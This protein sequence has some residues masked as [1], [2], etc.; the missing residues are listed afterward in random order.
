MP[1]KNDT[2]EKKMT[3]LDKLKQLSHRGS[4][5]I[6]HEEQVGKKRKEIGTVLKRSG[7]SP[8]CICFFLRS[9]RFLQVA[10]CGKESCNLIYRFH[11]D[12]SILFPSSSSACEANY[13]LKSILFK[14]LIAHSHRLSICFLSQNVLILLLVNIW[15]HSFAVV[16]LVFDVLLNRGLKYT[17]CVLLKSKSFAHV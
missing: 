6:A 15:W 13:S 12:S 10:V 16:I 11:H 3:S 5:D 8:Y 2:T 14:Y 1:I 4:V 7:L 9:H 17:D